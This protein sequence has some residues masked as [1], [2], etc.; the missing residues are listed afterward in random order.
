M[1]DQIKL[2]Y[3][4]QT[5]QCVQAKIEENEQQHEMDRIQNIKWA[6][7]HPK[8]ENENNFLTSKH[9]QVKPQSVKF[10]DNKRHVP[11]IPKHGRQYDRIPQH[12]VMT[13]ASKCSDRYWGDPTNIQQ[14]VK[15]EEEVQKEIDFNYGDADS[16]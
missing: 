10:R 6:K 12:Q 7:N 14:E 15:M 16:K 2:K 11:V 8:Q 1:R 9:Y 4:P 3:Y 13:N 5:Q